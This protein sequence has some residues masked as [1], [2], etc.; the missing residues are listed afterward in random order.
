MS[1]LT[2]RPE[3]STYR[4]RL[5]RHLARE[6]LAKWWLRILVEGLH[7]ILLG[8]IG[9]FMTGLLYQLR[10]LAG[11]FDEDAPRLLNTW[12]VGLSLSSVILGVVVAA[13]LHA[14][15]YEASPFGGPFSRFIVIVPA[16][17][18]TVAQAS[19]KPLDTMAE[20]LDDR[21]MSIRF[22][23]V[24][25]VIRRAITSPLW[26][27]LVALDRWRVELNL[28][29]RAKL[30]A[31]FM[32]L[33]AESS[34]PKLLERA[35]GSFSYVEWFENGA[36]TL[37]RMI[38]QLVKTWNRLTA[39]DTS[40]RVR[41]T[42]RARMTQFIKYHHEESTEITQKQI[43]VLARVCPIADRFNAEVY[44]ASFRADN[45]DLRPF[46]LLP[47][48]ECVARV[49]CSYNHKGKLGN[50]TEVFALAKIHC[51]DLLEEGKTDDVTRI[52]S[53]VDRLD[54][55]KS[56]IQY[57]GS[58][59]FI[60]LE[61]IVKDRRHEILRQINEFVKT[62]D[63]SRLGPLSLSQVIV[64]LASPPPDIDLSPLIGYISRH[65][66]SY[67]WKNISDTIVRYL[68]S[69]D[70]SQISDSAAVRRFLQLCV[71]TEVRDVDDNRCFNNDDT[72]ACARDLLVGESPLS[73]PLH[74]IDRTR[75]PRFHLSSQR[76]NRLYIHSTRITI[77]SSA[78]QHFLRTRTSSLPFRRLPFPSSR[79]YRSRHCP[80]CKFTL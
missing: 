62:V 76:C 58:I 30:V 11:S 36:G 38:E 67:I 60:L 45:A 52:L 63:R 14:L 72:R 15:T 65:P 23:K 35:A 69:F 19:E 25:P 4:E 46:S 61:F 44:S 41:E 79:K 74:S 57:S 22:Y 59:Y 56:S 8:S 78:P 75:R 37:E 21:V 32:D 39:T 9:L 12:K 48:E 27:P 53:H 43:E 68:N 31:A 47:F 20:W 80:F 26:F 29:D 34:D 71:D 50:R 55:I 70:L 42:L 51:N 3:G 18:N 77:P 49:L 73:F 24:V 54:L 7:I 5:L 16:I 6:A 28:D 2:S 17:M 13:T 66:H 64:V 33:T 10:N 1:K 40:V